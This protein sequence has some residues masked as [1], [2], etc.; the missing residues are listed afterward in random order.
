MGSAL[1][2]MAA[3]AFAFGTVLQQK[4]TLE[5]S[6]AENDPSFL[7]EIL[8]RP[9]WLI[10]AASQAVGWVLQAAA[11][12]RQSVIVV[13]SITALSLV[14]A[15]PIG[16]WL[17]NQRVGRKELTGAAA[18]MVGIIF[19]LAAGSPTGGTSQPS[20]STWWSACVGSLVAVTF[21][22][23]VGLRAR[24]AAR[25]LVF[26]SAAGLAFGLQAAVTKTFVDEIGHGVV[27]LLSSWSI[28]V[29]IVSA[30]IGF[31]LQ[32]SALKTGVLAP[33]MASANSVTLFSSVLLGVSVYGERLTG[34]GGG[35]VGA[36]VIGLT[37]AVVGV[38]ILAGSAP[39]TPT[40]H[41]GT[42]EQRPLAPG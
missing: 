31:A 16:V 30:I 6:L 19:F 13:Q 8:H 10:G 28:Y 32:Q 33:A 36:A 42:V 7:L 4:G 12:D 18:T 27:A 20:A 2:V 11:L 1:A 25:A 39:P 21:L 35:H 22:A 26:G 5:S 3:V 40:P 34:G 15:L 29:L 37:V 17:T 14:I 41:D 38:A 24:G 9:I 23:L